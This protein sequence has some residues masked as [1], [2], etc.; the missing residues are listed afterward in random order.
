M[1]TKFSTYYRYPVNCTKFRSLSLF[2][3]CVLESLNLQLSCQAVTFGNLLT[4]STVSSR[5]QWLAYAAGMSDGSMAGTAQLWKT[6]DQLAQKNGAHAT[7][8]WGN[9]NTYVG[10][11]KDNKK[12]GRGAL[13]SKEKG[14]RYEGDFK[15][16]FCILAGHLAI[17]GVLNASPSAL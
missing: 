4:C 2:K 6:H 9:K 13:T 17:L 1:H 12:N 11:W 15:V 5:V 7:V 10:Q 3:I 14:L 16:T 8:Y